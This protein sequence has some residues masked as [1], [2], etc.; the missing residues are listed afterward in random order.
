MRSDAIPIRC[1]IRCRARITGPWSSEIQYRA[2]LAPMLQV[3]TNG[4]TSEPAFRTGSV[5]GHIICLLV[6]P[7][8]DITSSEQITPSRPVTMPQHDAL[9]IGF[10]PQVCIICLCML[11]E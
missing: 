9:V 3:P 8:I 1:R 11:K 5:I 4:E 10:Q 6:L 2:L 7:N